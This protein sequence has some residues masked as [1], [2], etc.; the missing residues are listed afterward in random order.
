MREERQRQKETETD[1]C[2]ENDTVSAKQFLFLYPEVHFQTFHLRESVSSFYYNVAKI[3]AKRK[4]YLL[5]TAVPVSTTQRCFWSLPPRGLTRSP[6]FL[7][8]TAPLGSATQVSSYFC[9]SWDSSSAEH[10]PHAPVQRSLPRCL[11]PARWQ[12]FFNF[13]S[14]FSNVVYERVPD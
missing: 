6:S 12:Q 13:W 10:P 14:R 4:T 5:T 9:F 3:T 7:G 2:R 8:P 11:H 1:T